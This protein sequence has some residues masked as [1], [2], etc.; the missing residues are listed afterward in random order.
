MVFELSLCRKKVWVATSVNDVIC[1]SSMIG[2]SVLFIFVRSYSSFTFSSPGVG[3]VYFSI[4]WPIWFTIVFHSWVLPPTNSL[5]KLVTV[6]FE[7]LLKNAIVV[8]VRFWLE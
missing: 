3:E 2:K 5:S 4:F 8:C 6:K 1:G 7:L